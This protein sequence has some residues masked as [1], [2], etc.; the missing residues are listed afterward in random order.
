MTSLTNS[1]L[2]GRHLVIEY[3]KDEDENIDF[4]RKRA[5][6]DEGVIKIDKKKRKI[7]DVADGEGSAGVGSDDM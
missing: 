7:D 2:Y 3:A 6:L 5:R 4:L 1:H